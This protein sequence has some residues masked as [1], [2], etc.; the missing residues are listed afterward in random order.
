MIQVSPD[1]YLCHTCLPQLMWD[2]GPSPQKAHHFISTYNCLICPPHL[3][4]VSGPSPG[5]WIIYF[6]CIQHITT[7]GL[8]L[9]SHVV[10]SIHHNSHTA[11]LTS[12]REPPQFL[13]IYHID[14]RASPVI[15]PMHVLV[16]LRATCS[17]HTTRIT[18]RPLSSIPT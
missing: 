6:A 1:L 8:A 4:R 17:I 9:T 3:T 2:S 11:L 5:A 18:F 7:S 10:K 16:C 14:S 12:V 15:Y 13:C